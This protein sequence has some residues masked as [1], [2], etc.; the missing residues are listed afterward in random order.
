MNHLKH[1]K[2][3]ALEDVVLPKGRPFLNFF[4]DLPTDKHHVAT[5]PSSLSSTHHSSP[6]SLT[7]ELTLVITDPPTD[8]PSD[9][10]LLPGIHTVATP[11]AALRSSAASMSIQLSDSAPM[12]PMSGDETEDEYPTHGDK[13]EDEAAMM[14]LNVLSS[15]TTIAAKSNYEKPATPSKRRCIENV[16]VSPGL[17]AMPQANGN[18]SLLANDENDDYRSLKVMLQRP[19]FIPKKVKI[20][21]S[22]C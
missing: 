11:A 17:R 22:I 12:D 18:M 2:K 16:N 9:S 3:G 19:F 5:S 1:C 15:G 8:P 13:K 6:L 10:I 4:S 7:S 21:S 14:L 20:L